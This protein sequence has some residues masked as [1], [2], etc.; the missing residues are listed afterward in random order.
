MPAELDRERGFAVTDVLPPRVDKKVC[1]TSARVGSPLRNSLRQSP[2]DNGPS[3]LF[4]RPCPGQ[5]RRR[6]LPFPARRGAS[7]PG[8]PH[9][10]HDPADHHSDHSAHWRR[11]ILRPRSLVL[12]KEKS[13]ART[14][15]ERTWRYLAQFQRTAAIRSSG[16]VSMPRPRLIS[17]AR[18]VAGNEA[19]AITAACHPCVG[20]RAGPCVPCADHH[21]AH[22]DLCA[23]PVA[24]SY[25]WSGPQPLR[26]SASWLALRGPTPIRERTV[27]SDVRSFPA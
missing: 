16:P 4:H 8:G 18:P 15:A 5:P 14:G 20:R 7:G 22:G 3:S 13:P 11:R 17:R 25:R 2:F 19:A 10:H 27:A 26:P 12:T 24:G 9:G 23:D 1:P 6:C 21:A